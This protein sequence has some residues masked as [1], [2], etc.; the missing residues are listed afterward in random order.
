[1]SKTK[2]P[3]TKS[4]L[5]YHHKIVIMKQRELLGFFSTVFCKNY[6][7]DHLMLDLVSNS[8]LCQKSQTFNFRL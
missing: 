1:M 6:G 3:L 4:P 5:T 8:S 2:M 7:F